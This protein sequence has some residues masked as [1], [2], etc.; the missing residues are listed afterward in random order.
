VEAIDVHA[1]F[2]PVSRFRE[3]RA[4]APEHVPVIDHVNGDVYFRYPSGLE[5][6]PVPKAI[7]DIEQRLIEMEATEVTHQVLSARPQ[8]FSY[9]L[10]GDV[11]SALASWSN[12]ALV[13]VASA[14]PE[15]FSV[16]I[17]LPLQ[18]ADASVA[19]IERWAQHRVVRGV[20]IDSNVA[21]RDFAEPAFAPIWAAL[22]AAD[23]PVLVH[24]YQ[25]DVVGKDRLAKH[26]LFNLIGNP[27]DTTIA[28]AN[29]VFGGLVDLYPALRW[30][31]VHGGGVAPYLAGRWDHGWHKRAVTRELIPHALPSEILS[32]FW[33]D[34]IV[35]DSRTLNY[36]AEGVGWDRIMLGSDCPFDMGYTDPVSFVD[37]VAEAE[38][39][40]EAVLYSNANDFLRS[41]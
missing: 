31:F 17:A 24:P 37:Q 19:E 6:G 1:H 20:M 4:I 12:D 26:Y 7:V 9:D 25:G 27:V 15:S 29:V 32:S 11:A 22:E 28:I 38:Q 18:D 40:R 14:Y 39:H 33:Y 8:M 41:R 13:D 2:A 21:G 16:L 3:M 30:G 35:H 36:L 5:N 23:L 34:C 10:P